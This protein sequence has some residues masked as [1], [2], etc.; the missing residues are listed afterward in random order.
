MT[1][2]MYQSNEEIVKEKEDATSAKDQTKNDAQEVSKTVKRMAEDETHV[3]GMV[4][5][6]TK[7]LSNAKAK[8]QATAHEEAVVE[9]AKDAISQLSQVASAKTAEAD[10]ARDQSASAMD[11]AT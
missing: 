11:A 9:S 4:S 8:L 3:A 7:L 10:A 5:G 6:L 2:D 1:G